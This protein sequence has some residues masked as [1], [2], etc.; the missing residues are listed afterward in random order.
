MGS[1]KGTSSGLVCSLNKDEV[2]EEREDHVNQKPNHQE[3]DSILLQW[4]GPCHPT[5]PCIFHL[6]AAP[7]SFFYLLS[8]TQSTISAG[9]DSGC[10]HRPASSRLGRGLAVLVGKI[11]GNCCRRV[12]GLG[13]AS[14]V[15]SVHHRH[16]RSPWPRGEFPGG[17][18][19]LSDAT[20][21]VVGGAWRGWLARSRAR[22]GR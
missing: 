2:V 16:P 22:W 15:P 11:L 7:F 18:R 21:E 5:H 20:D 4:H 8:I 3:A 14:E 6:P 13:A 17:S 10:G 1:D 9:E 12:P 19:F